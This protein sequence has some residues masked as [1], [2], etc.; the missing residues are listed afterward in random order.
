[1]LAVITVR[2][3]FLQWALVHTRDLEEEDAQGQGS[4]PTADKQLVLR[5]AATILL[6]FQFLFAV[7]AGRNAALGIGI[8]AGRIFSYFK[9]KIQSSSKK[10]CE[11]MK[12]KQKIHLKF[13]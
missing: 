10:C 7:S 12:N 5:F 11:I 2:L 3:H 6:S 8:A 9:A 1:L 4:P 13:K